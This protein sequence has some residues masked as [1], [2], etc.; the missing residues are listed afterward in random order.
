M[1]GRGGEVGVDEAISARNGDSEQRKRGGGASVSAL[2]SCA[3]RTDRI[4]IHGEPD[5]FELPRP[6]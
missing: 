4:P 6:P 2:S 1:K 5:P 3:R